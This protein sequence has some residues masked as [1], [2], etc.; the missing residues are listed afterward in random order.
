MF[1]YCKNMWLETI[2]NTAFSTLLIK[3]LKKRFDW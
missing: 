3:L 1:D 2:L